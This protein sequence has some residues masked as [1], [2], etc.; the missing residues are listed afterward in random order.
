[1]AEFLTLDD[2]NVA[3]K[4][5]LLRVDINVP[6]DPGTGRISDSE[7]L[8]AHAE[9]VK[10]L[11]DK[12]AR[13]V[14]LAHQGRRGDPDFIHLDQH[15]KLLSK[16]TGKQVGF[17]DDVVGE[18]AESSIRRL[19]G[20]EILL[21]DNVRFLD[22]ET[23]EKP[24]SEHSRSIIVEALAPLG[25]LYVNDAFSAAHRSH[26]SIVG[27]TQVMPSAAGRV[28]EHELKAC[29]K[30]LNPER[31]N[32]FI[33]GGAKPEDCISIMRHMLSKG[34]LDMVLSCGLVGQ[35]VLAARGVDLGV[36]NKAFLE[37]K[38][39][40]PLLSKIEELDRKHGDKIEA[41]MDVAVEADGVRLELPVGD[42]PTQHLIMDIG[43]E[44]VRRYSE[45]LRKARTVVVKG[46][47]GVYEKDEFKTG[48]RK[49]LEVVSRL[50]AYTLI[51]GGDTSVAAEQ[52]GFS[53]SAFSYVSIAGGAL[54][55]YLSGE[56][57]PG[58]EALREAA[59][60]FKPQI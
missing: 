50:K 16:H 37:K 57:M 14:I 23:L 3:G 45:I 33:L 11:A 21:L 6:Y 42:L 56:P 27:F 51:G 8:R 2:F 5:V 10:E 25:D 46:P 47:A 58:V 7:R 35:L 4:T 36:E 55:T 39:A 1:M 38:K 19:R 17:I 52:L 32:M 31:P 49:L 60:R 18:K 12:R 22:D 34:L 13:V 28:M 41:P 43:S 53:K 26:A 29:E 9:T 48:T 44:T 30:A 40:L 54:I 59:K 20:G 15:A 24:V